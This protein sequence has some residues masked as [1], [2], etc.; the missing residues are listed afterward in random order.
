MS[1]P[2]TSEYTLTTEARERLVQQLI[3]EAEQRRHTELLKLIGDELSRCKEM[4]Q[5]LEQ[6]LNELE[7]IIDNN[8]FD[9]SE[10][11]SCKAE[12]RRIT[13]YIQSFT[14]GESDSNDVL[15]L[16]ESELS[17]TFG[18]AREL[19][20][21]INKHNEKCGRKIRGNNIASV[22]EKARSAAKEATEKHT[23]DLVDEHV[24]A[25]REKAYIHD[26]IN[27]AMK[28]LGYNVIGDRSFTRADG[29]VFKNELYKVGD[30]TVVNV[31]FSDNETITMELGAADSKDRLPTYQEAEC[32]V[33][34]MEVFCSKYTDLERILLNKG[35]CSKLVRHMPATA[36]F[37]QVINVSE[38]SIKDT[39]DM[40]ETKK[41]KRPVSSQKRMRKGV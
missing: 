40:Y 28:E 9:K 7:T 18:N 15:G 39:T 33:E 6:E 34:D 10:F 31:S 8:Q 20:E 23:K 13:S 38:Y 19:E 36:E 17:D 41:R 27:D 5:Y 30:G 2:K 11:D 16:K 37:A 32:L 1:G 29:R 4:L 35:V 21:R 14:L 25:E 22:F 24:L 3:K 12:L 26:S